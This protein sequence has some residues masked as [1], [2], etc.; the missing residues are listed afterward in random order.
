MAS[1]G[2]E[3]D[4]ALAA[5][6]GVLSVGVTMAAPYGSKVETVAASTFRG[7]DDNKASWPSGNTIIFRRAGLSNEML[8]TLENRN[9][10]LVVALDVMMVPTKHQLFL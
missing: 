8:K 4:K 1:S 2:V 9:T 7:H 5:R 10:T 3:Q 6:A